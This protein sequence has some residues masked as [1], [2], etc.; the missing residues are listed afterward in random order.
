L[1]KIQV[2]L[3]DY[4]NGVTFTSPEAASTVTN[5]TPIAIRAT[6]GNEAVWDLGLVPRGQF[7]V[8]GTLSAGV[9]TIVGRDPNPHEV[10]GVFNSLIRLRNAITNKDSGEVGRVSEMLDEDLSRLSASR[11]SLGITQ[12]QIDDL[13]SVQEDRNIEL[14]ADESRNLDA[15]MA[16]TISELN[17]RQ[18]AY[19]ANL[20]LLANATRLSLFDFI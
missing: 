8:H 20:R 5:P 9:Y 19:E 16:T 7:E 2:A 11:A 4:G 12:Q 18:T 15:D 10:R 13:K 6:G 14:K 1:N 3:N 17:A